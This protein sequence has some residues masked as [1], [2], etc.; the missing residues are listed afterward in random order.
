VL[1]AD[2][3]EFLL[4][5]VLRSFVLALVPVVIASFEAATWL[6]SDANTSESERDEGRMTGRKIPVHPLEPST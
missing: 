2:V 4:A 3:V 1:A 5:I 6:L